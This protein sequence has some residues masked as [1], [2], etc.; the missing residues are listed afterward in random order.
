MYQTRVQQSSSG[1]RV[2]PVSTTTDD[3][4]DSVP[5]HSI[6]VALTLA[7][8]TAPAVYNNV[9]LDLYSFDYTGCPDFP[10]YREYVSPLYGETV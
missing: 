8:L 6:P 5:Q 10:G 1:D 3:V 4:I 7:G 2:S 9:Q